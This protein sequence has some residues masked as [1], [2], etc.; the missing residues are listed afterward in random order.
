[1]NLVAPALIVFGYAALVAKAGPPGL[2]V[3][4]V[5]IG[6]MCWAASRHRRDPRA[7]RQ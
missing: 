6:I 3:A 4:V 1:M 5:H 7:P 2:L